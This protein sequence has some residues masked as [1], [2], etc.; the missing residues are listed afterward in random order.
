P[1]MNAND[2]YLLYIARRYEDSVEQLQ[3]TLEMDLMFAPTHYRLG[4]AYDALGVRE[5]AI[6]H[7]EQALQFS[8]GGP[9]ALGALAYTYARAGRETEAEEV[10][11][12]LTEMSKSR[13]V[14]AAVF[15]EVFI[16]LSRHDE[17]IDWL[18]RAVDERSAALFTFGVDPRFD[19]LRS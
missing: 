1:I 5:K 2:G 7:L 4:L 8:D 18:K 16:G 14:S 15:A 11:R 6:L 3:A 10:L 17:A 13:Y 9:F 19:E 12:R